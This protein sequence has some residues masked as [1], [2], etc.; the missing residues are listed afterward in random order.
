MADESSQPAAVGRM[1]G[2]LELSADEL[3]A[4][5]RISHALSKYR[6]REALFAAVA[7]AVEGVLPAERLVVLVPKEP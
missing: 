4:L 5:L 1:P 3:A 6:D 2:R 7:E